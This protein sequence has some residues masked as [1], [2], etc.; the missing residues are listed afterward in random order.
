MRILSLVKLHY[1]KSDIALPNFM[2]TTAGKPIPS[3][4]KLI[5]I[6]H[7]QPTWNRKPRKHNAFPTRSFGTGNL[8][9]SGISIVCLSNITM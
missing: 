4:L 1:S 7:M 6:C 8:I 2:G 3:I 9:H 5:P